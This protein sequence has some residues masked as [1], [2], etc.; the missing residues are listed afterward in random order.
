MTLT[1]RLALTMLLASGACLR[2]DPVLGTSVETSYL[3][4]R[5]SF[6]LVTVTEVDRTLVVEDPCPSRLLK[7]C[8]GKVKPSW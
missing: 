7:S 5:E 2:T 4:S 6:K 3:N 1:W 8:Q